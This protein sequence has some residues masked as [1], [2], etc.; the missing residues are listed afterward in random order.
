MVSN[1]PLRWCEHCAEEF[2]PSRPSRRYCSRACGHAARSRE[3]RVAAGRK[4]GRISGERKRRQADYRRTIHLG[5]VRQAAYRL[6]Y[7]EGRSQGYQEG[8]EACE[9]DMRMRERR[10][11]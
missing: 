11:A 6:G 9:A 4:G 3:A 2:R 10:T 5:N 1:R 7:G 8:W